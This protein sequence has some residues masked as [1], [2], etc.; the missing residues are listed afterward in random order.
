[1]SDK[2]AEWLTQ[3]RLVTPEQL[4]TAQDTQKQVGGKL[5][6]ILAKLRYVTEEQLTQLMSKQMG[7]PMLGLKDLVVSPQV[8]ALID[9][10][11]LEKH[12]LLPLR[13][14]EDALIL[15]VSDPLDF[16]AIDEIRFLTGL[17]T[18]LAVSTRLDIQ[19]AID[20]YCHGRSNPELEEAEAAYRASGGVAAAA[21]SGGAKGR[22]EVAPTVLL[23]ALVE[24]LAEKQVISREELFARVAR[25][26]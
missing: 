8:S 9:V 1:M 14:T 13:R 23:K 22:V 26:K 2:L 19:K 16:A 10:E 11:V 5:P 18:D 7:L 12:Q 20:Y 6:V 24:L 3:A 15:A 4:Q 17:R 21:G 25:H